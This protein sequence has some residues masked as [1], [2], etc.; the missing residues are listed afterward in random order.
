MENVNTKTFLKEYLQHRLE[1]PFRLENYFIDTS[2]IIAF[3]QSPKRRGK[4][5]RSTSSL[6]L[7]SLCNTKP[8]HVEIPVKEIVSQ[9]S[10]FD[11]HKNFLDVYLIL[12]FFF[13]RKYLGLKP[14]TLP[15]CN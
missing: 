10:S 9:R 12:R 13:A 4:F 14:Q 1:D 6:I 3:L 8:N 7:L 11:I 2:L 15:L 5:H